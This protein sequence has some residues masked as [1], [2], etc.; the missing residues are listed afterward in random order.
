M[1][2]HRYIHLN[3][4]MHGDSQVQHTPAC[5][6]THTHSL[7]PPTFLWYRVYNWIPTVDLWWSPHQHFSSQFMWSLSVAGYLLWHIF[8]K[9][10]LSPSPSCLIHR[11]FALCQRLIELFSGISTHSVN[12]WE[13][14]KCLQLISPA[15]NSNGLYVLVCL[16]N[17]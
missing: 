4:C 8:L 11:L 3:M 12:K 5:N 1:G 6:H 7:A 10:S 16:C 15:G 13:A 9:I 17:P 14:C 2:P